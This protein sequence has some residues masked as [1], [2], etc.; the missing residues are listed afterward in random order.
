MRMSAMWVSPAGAGTPLGSPAALQQPRTR[1]G[2]GCQ[3]SEEYF[4]HLVSYLQG[5]AKYVCWKCSYHCNPLNLLDYWDADG[6]DAAYW[7]LITY[8]AKGRGKGNGE[9][10]GGRR[11]PPSR[12][13]PRHTQRAPVRSSRKSW[14][15]GK[16]C[17]HT[18]WGNPTFPVISL[19]WN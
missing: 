12:P 13:S 15:A 19:S 14:K 3:L 4:C 5:F 10:A 18:I 9:A 7:K 8:V 1:L 6:H 2:S 11:Q 16:W 17:C